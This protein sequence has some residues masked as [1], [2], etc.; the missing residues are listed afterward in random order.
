MSEEGIDGT[1]A[2]QPDA[3]DDGL[4]TLTNAGGPWNVGEAP[5]GLDF[6]DFGP[7]K[8]PA[9]PGLRARLEID[10]DRN[11]IGA[12]TVR[13]G[14]SALQLQVIA[15][16][17]GVS[18]WADTRQALVANL[19]KR[20]GHQ[21]V[22]EG[23]YGTEVIGVLTGRTPEGVLLDA[24]MRFQGVENDTWLIRAVSSGPSVTHDDVASRVDAFLSR[25]AVDPAA[26]A[27]VAPGTVIPLTDPP[28]G[29]DAE[30]AEALREPVSEE[31]DGE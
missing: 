3:A 21:Q 5:E 31:S 4:G 13:I 25:C 12:V 29:I 2:H 26:V 7:L 10:P 1:E 9:L 14:D 23:H 24:T 22:I 8:L 16:Q 17:R 6:Y 11:E 18:Q 19:R 30:R 20:P 28:G 15:K 27:G